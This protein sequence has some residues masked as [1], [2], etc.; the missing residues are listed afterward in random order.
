[1]KK[2]KRKTIR[3]S[4]STDEDIALIHSLY[5]Y[6]FTVE[7]ISIHM[8]KDPTT[9]FRYIQKYGFKRKTIQEFLDSEILR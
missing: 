9:I 1:M 3:G 7:N 2:L 6:N 8:K 4:N 5:E